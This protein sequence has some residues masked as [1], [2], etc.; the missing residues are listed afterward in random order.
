MKLIATNCL[1]G[2]ERKTFGTL[3]YNDTISWCWQLNAKIK[4][5]DVNVDVSNVFEILVKGKI[6]LSI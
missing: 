5:K 1:V 2:F 6:C 4:I 3:G